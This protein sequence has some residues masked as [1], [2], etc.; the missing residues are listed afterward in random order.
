MTLSLDIHEASTFKE[1]CSVIAEG[2]AARQRTLPSDKAA[3]IV[4]KPNLNSFMNGLTGNTTDLRVI[5]ALLKALRDMGYTDLTIA[6]GT[7]SG[8]YRNNIGV[9]HRLR[10]DTLADHYGASVVDCNHASGRPVPFG[11]QVTAQVAATCMDADFLINIPKLKTHFEAGMSVCLKNLIGC[12]IGQENKRKTHLDLPGNIVRL[13]QALR[14]HLHVVDAMISMEGCG[15]S[16]GTPVHSDMLIIGDDPYL[17]D[18][19]CARLTGIA[20]GIITPLVFARDQGL[21]T[22]AHFEAVEA[23]DMRGFGRKFE[24]AKPSLAATIAHLSPASGPLR[25]LRE[26]AFGTWLAS[27]ALFGRI[28]YLSGIRQ[29][30]FDAKDADIR[31]LRVNARCNQCGICRDFCP[32]GADPSQG[33]G[34]ND[35]PCIA[36]LYCFMVCPQKALEV[37]GELG[38]I[39]EQMQRYDALV[40][41]QATRPGGLKAD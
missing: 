26:S 19:A 37:D 10:V 4:L 24:R 1:A 30:A 31:G 8:F 3:R 7:N 39:E 18:L 25:S 22:D 9:I 12:L 38:C 27:T 32:V 21:L 20:P 11:N 6:E 15:P 36:C 14:P 34:V 40:R 13:N 29:D 5:S 23:I 28:L 16:R 2:L 41:R 17:I 33:P 35:A